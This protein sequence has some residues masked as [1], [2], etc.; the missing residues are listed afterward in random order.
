LLLAAVA[1][2]GALFSGSPPVT[3]GQEFKPSMRVPEGVGVDGNRVSD[4]LDA[5]IAARLGNGMG[6]EL[7]SVVVMLSR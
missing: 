7:A 5:G 2:L 6:G 1:S 4:G 3:A